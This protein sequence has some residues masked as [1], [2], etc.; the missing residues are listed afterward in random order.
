MWEV[1]LSTTQKSEDSK[2]D[3]LAFR[4]AFVRLVDTMNQMEIGT[5]RSRSI[6]ATFQS[7]IDKG[8]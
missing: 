3:G 2:A 6:G 7:W 8:L 5:D 1:C 4:R